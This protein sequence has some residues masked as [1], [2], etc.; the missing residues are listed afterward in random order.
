MGS[1]CVML[2]IVM[3]DC[4]LRHLRV[5]IGVSTCCCSVYTACVMGAIDKGGQAIAGKC[6]YP[7][8]LLVL[9]PM[10]ACPL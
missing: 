8:S 1:L 10:I 3:E 5:T 2:P 4:V 6:T 9:L 7:M